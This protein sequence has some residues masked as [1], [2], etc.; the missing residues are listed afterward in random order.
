MADDLPSGRRSIDGLTYYL[1]G[2]GALVP[3]SVVKATDKLEDDLV[4][5]IIGKALPVSDL[6]AKF[7]QETFEDVDEF[8]ALLEQEYKA[9]RGG[10]KGNLTFTSFDGLLKIQVQVSETITFGPELQVAKSLVDECLREW[11]RDSGDEIKAIINRAFQ[12]DSQGRI[13][14]NDLLGLLRLE[15]EDERWQDAMRAI[16]D[17]MRVVGSKRYVRMYRRAFT[18]A[19]WSAITIDVAAG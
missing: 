7:R 9:K 2:D 3:E 11:S 18:S 16:R 13:N 17:S 19:P 5:W 15:I 4:R 6:V 10:A 1:N 12:V 8:V 14:R